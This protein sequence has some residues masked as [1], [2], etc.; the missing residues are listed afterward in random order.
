[1]DGKELEKRLEKAK[2]LRGRLEGLFD[3][4]IRLTMPAR[5]RF[6][7]N[8]VDRA[9]DIFDETGANG[10]SEFVSRM[11]AG[12]APPFTRFVKLEASSHV[13]KSDRAAVNRDLD[14]IEDYL[15]E[16]IWASNF[17]QETAESFHDLCISTGNMIVDETPSR[18]GVVNR[19][20]P[21]TSVF[22]EAGPD[23]RVGGVFRTPPEVKAADLEA[24]YP[25]AKFNAETK[26]KI[27][28]EEDKPLEVVE[29]MKTVF[30]REEPTYEYRVYVRETKDMI[31]ERTFVGV[32]ANPIITF[33]W[34][35]AAGE[36]W[37]RGPLLN[38]MGAI[39]TT[40]LMVELVLENAAMAIVGIYQTD[41]DGTV[42][43]DNIELLPGTIIPKEIGSTGLEP[44]RGPT[45]DFNMRDIVLND[46]RVNIKRALFNDMLSDPNRTPATAYEVSE[47]MADL[48]YRTAAGFS[49]THY[50]F[51][52]PYIQRML[53]LLEKRGSIEL[54][55]D[56]RGI[57]YRAV[58][59]LAQA[60]H[61]RDLQRFMEDY[62]I[63]AGVWGPQVAA[64]M[65][66]LEEAIPWLNEKV[67]LA[68]KLYK[69][70]REVTEAIAKQTAALQMMQAQQDMAKGAK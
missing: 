4:A 43:A 15:F 44:V 29:Y 14:E 42:N 34:A 61:G 30:G 11:M 17:M 69:S 32:G 47:R 10:V 2:G 58:S 22:L 40:N 60:Q 25:S 51:T 16:E 53:Y 33:R 67:G 5:A 41:N 65:Y 49:R 23:G 21:I 3:D 68:A 26:R 45:G 24:R 39:R 46:Q 64:S 59:P 36:V 56:R 19:A 57:A 70:P 35:T 1:M 62:Q 54:P 38:A 28:A 6:H 63:R 7:T 55:V 8:N 52:V 13:A 50:E 31:I 27:A 66:D 12:S 37:G 20:I 18:N 48:G 9:E